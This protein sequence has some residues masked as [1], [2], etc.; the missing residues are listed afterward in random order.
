MFLGLDLKAGDDETVISMRY[1]PMDL[2]FIPCSSVTEWSPIEVMFE[3]SLSATKAVNWTEGPRIYTR[4]SAKFGDSFKLEKLEI[5]LE[6]IIL[7]KAL[8]S[9]SAALRKTMNSKFSPKL[10]LWSEKFR[11]FKHSPDK[12]L[13]TS[14]GI[15]VVD[16]Y[17]SS[18]MNLPSDFEVR[19]NLALFLMGS[20][21]GWEITNSDNWTDWLALPDANGFTEMNPQPV[22][23]VVCSPTVSQYASRSTGPKLLD[24][25]VL[26]Q[27]ISDAAKAASNES[28][29][30]SNS[31]DSSQCKP[32]PSTT[33]VSQSNTG[34]NTQ[35]AS[36]FLGTGSNAQQQGTSS[37]ASYSIKCKVPGCGWATESYEDPQVML[38]LVKMEE[39]H[40]NRVHSEDVKDK[41]E[42]DS[43]AVATKRIFMEG[44]MDNRANLLCKGRFLSFG[45]NWELAAKQA[46]I[47][48][49]PVFSKW[50]LTHLG[51]SIHNEKAVRLL[52]DRTNT[53][54]KLEQF[55]KN[56]IE[57]S[58]ADSKKTLKMD[59]TKIVEEPDLIPLGSAHDALDSVHIWSI[60]CT[61]INPGDLGPMIVHRFLWC[62]SKNTSLD[63]K[64]IKSF[65]KR[66]QVDNANR[67]GR[68]EAPYS[69]QEL[70]TLFNVGDFTMTVSSEVKSS[71]GSS[72]E[73]KKV[74]SALSNMVEKLVPK[75]ED[76]GN[77]SN[78]AKSK[79][80]N[81][82]GTSTSGKS[83]VMLCRLFNTA[84]GCGRPTIEGGY[85]CHD[86]KY[87]N[88]KSHV[89][90]VQG[91]GARNHNS[92][93]HN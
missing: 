90:A 72:G 46:P 83:G 78:N 35:G 37:K 71:E 67:I 33:F 25:S 1:R 89:C 86:G 80:K 87:E 3:T 6:A 34:C 69:Y 75:I 92:L 65:W 60:L 55:S 54:L 20:R 38:S 28:L 7:P 16:L 82:D 15:H 18:P 79:F 9:Y 2:D 26:S 24:N 17:A 10:V 62:K 31:Q 39:N 32:I 44:E 48:Q 59:G 19:S 74:I 76:N 40:H 4:W 57:K 91:C 56:N 45:T 73:L 41:K 49:T 51:I 8:E 66:A 47:K 42:D 36:S 27:V 93:N 52:H 22:P 29:F 85:F 64:T 88:V 11:W 23:L 77:V 81:S 21:S 61:L 43:Y 13:P 50:D 5:R 14:P 70:G 53:S 58:S 63:L 30:G 68:G 84:R 12:F